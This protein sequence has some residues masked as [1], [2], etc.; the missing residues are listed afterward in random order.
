MELFSIYEL[1]EKTFTKDKTHITCFQYPF[2]GIL[3]GSYL[4]M[5]KDFMRKLLFIPLL[6]TCNNLFSQTLQQLESK[7]V[8]LPNGWSLTPVGKS[9]P[10]GDLPLNMAVSPSKKLIAITNNGQS[11]QSLQLIDA[12]NDKVL[13]SVV[14]PKS[15]YGLKF[16]GDE[17]FLYASGGTDNWILKYA[18]QKNNLVLKDSTKLGNKWPRR[19][20]PTGIEIDDA[21]KTMYVG[22]KENNMLY[23][24]N[25]V[26]KTVNDSIKLDGEVYGLVLSPDKKR[27][28]VSV[29]GND[30]VIVLNT[31]TKAIYQHIKVGD[32]PN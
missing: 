32:N 7:R 22:T 8:G 18:I 2:A 25:L 28:Y 11:V 27:L 4:S 5:M 30:E 17:K 15:W 12:V 6:I 29:W 3:L 31:T 16:S 9:L 20:S 24:V 1:P 21:K 10:L 14:I 19:I 23:I 13:S 26:S